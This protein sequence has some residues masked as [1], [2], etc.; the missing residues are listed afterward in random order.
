MLVWTPEC[1]IPVQDER[2]C[3]SRSESSFGTGVRSGISNSDTY[4][5]VMHYHH[6]KP[7]TNIL[8]PYYLYTIIVFISILKSLLNSFSF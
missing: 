2:A 8:Q 1:S 5:Q 3:V 4:E 6:V 7:N